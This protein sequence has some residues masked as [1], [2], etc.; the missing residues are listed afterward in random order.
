VEEFYTDFN[1]I[2]NRQTNLH[3]DTLNHI[4]LRLNSELPEVEVERNPNLNSR[5]DGDTGKL[6]IWEIF[7]TI[8][9]K[10][11]SGQD[12]KNRTIF[13]DFLFLDRANRDVGDKVMINIEK[14]RT[15]L[16]GDTG[17]YTLYDVVSRIFKD[18]NFTF[19]PTPVYIN[20]Y[21]LDDRV[22]DGEPIPQ[23]I[24]NDLFGTFMEVDTRNSRPKMLGIYVGKPSEHIDDKGNNKS[25]RLDDAFDLT[26]ASANPLIENQINKTDYA[27]SNKCVGFT[28]D[29]GTRNQGIF[30]TIDID[31]SQYK[32]TSETYDILE[33]LGDLSS[34]QSVAQQSQSMYTIYK[35]RSFNCKV[36]SLGNAMIQPTMYFNLRHVPMFNG[37]YLI[38]NVNH[39]ISGGQFTT[40]FE[41]V[42]IP[43]SALKIPD[44]LA[45][46]VN[47]EL[48][49][50][51]QRKIF[52]QAEKQKELDDL[53]LNLTNNLLSGNFKPAN[54]S[55]CEGKTEYSEKPF[56]T[57]V[58]SVI[59]G[60]DLKTSIENT[61]I[62]DDLKRFIYGIAYIETGLESGGFGVNNNNIFNIR[63]DINH[64]PISNNF[65]SQIC[66]NNGDY[67][68]PYGSFG[69]LDNAVKFMT[70]KYQSFDSML[71]S[72]YDG[73][74]N[75]A[76][77]YG[78]T[79][80][81]AST[82]KDDFGYGKTANEIRESV[83][84]LM[85]ENQLFVNTFDTTQSK[86]IRALNIYDS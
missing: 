73:T 39:S 63:T 36:S 55:E 84:T 66:L 71:S 32:N 19:M 3:R 47:K 74:T 51:L 31:M 6:E 10:W 68:L 17:K 26:R 1:N 12:F 67:V 21:G 85:D 79:V 60:N 9:D 11:V 30:K 16:K 80:L 61:T 46:S 14:L 43:T 64:G 69:L 86:F 59:N 75:E 4:F 29:F 15:M 65:E 27:N 53:T 24:P 8:N 78:M 35:S 52:R 5:L 28:V 25:R 82:W 62:S 81:W 7:R 23:D 13:E 41:G 49:K 38:I 70:E 18:N 83:V 22:K 45:M 76:K 34:L 33:Q 40:Q 72:L 57:V 48:L 56:V 50:T 44:K 20:F 2:L 37:P 58:N 54:E 42:R 77:A